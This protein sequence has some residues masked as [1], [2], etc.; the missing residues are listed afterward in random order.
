MSNALQVPAYLMNRVL[1]RTPESLIRGIGGGQPPHI[2]LKGNRFTM[3]NAAG[4]ERPHDQLWLDAVIVDWNPEISKTYYAEKYDPR[5]ENVGPSC[6]S[7]NGKTPNPDAPSPQNS[8]C[9]TCPMNAWGSSVSALTGKGVKACSDSKK[10]AV[11][12]PGLGDDTAFLVRIPPGS[13]KALAAYVVTMCGMSLGAR[14]ADPSD[15]ITRISFNPQ[16]Q[17]ILAFQ[18]IGFID[19]RVATLLE[20]FDESD[21]TAYLVGRKSEQ[22]ACLPP[23]PSNSHQAQNTQMLPVPPHLVLPTPPL[24][25]QALFVP[26]AQRDQ[27][28][29]APAPIK[30]PRALKP[31]ESA[32]SLNSPAE[33]PLPPTA[34]FGMTTA[35]PPDSALASALSKHF[36][37]AVGAA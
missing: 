22:T 16:A 18:A 21:S 13:L 32:L 6:F 7:D 23:P 12:I 34:G 10:L 25:P 14:S 4:E 28:M 27:G 2:S 20:G 29:N 37:L 8:V 24:A 35:L 30:K 15:V 9:A 3:V 11:I 1:K 33:V 5:V 19:E 17:G 36:N 26:Q 31:V